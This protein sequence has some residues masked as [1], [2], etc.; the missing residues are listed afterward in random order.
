MQL[1]PP[2]RVEGLGLIRIPRLFGPWPKQMHDEFATYLDAM[3]RFED[4]LREHKIA[5]E[6]DPLSLEARIQY[7]DSFFYARRYSE[8]QAEYEEVA[9]L[10]P[11]FA[12][13]H[14]ALGWLYLQQGK[15]QAGMEEM[16]KTM[17]LDRGSGLLVAMS[18]AIS[19]N[20]VQARTILQQTLSSSKGQYISGVSVAFVYAAMKDQDNVCKWLERAYRDHDPDIAFFNVDPSHDVLR[21]SSCFRDIIRR[22][23]FR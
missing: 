15:F 17:E 1:P 21:S 12:D 6:R 9:R 13:A 14:R 20:T 18:Y 8:A 11:S 3:G 2:S 4:G 16:R 19:G 10:A 7:G 23:N 5:L 22:V